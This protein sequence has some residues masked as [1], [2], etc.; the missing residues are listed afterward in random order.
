MAS[1]QNKHVLDLIWNKYVYTI[2]CDLGTAQFAKS[3]TY[4]KVTWHVVRRSTCLIEST[5]QYYNPVIFATP[6]SKRGM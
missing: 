2:H 4:L 3:F 1:V 5:P 6:F